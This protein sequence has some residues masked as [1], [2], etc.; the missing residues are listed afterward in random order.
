MQRVSK[1]MQKIGVVEIEKKVVLL[2]MVHL[3]DQNKV[4]VKIVILQKKVEIKET[5]GR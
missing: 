1:N 3:A 5:F 2:L 4:E